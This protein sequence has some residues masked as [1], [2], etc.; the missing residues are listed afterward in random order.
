MITTLG[1]TTTLAAVNARK[2]EQFCFFF[3]RFVFQ[4][5]QETAPHSLDLLSCQAA[6]PSCM[7][8]ILDS[9]CQEGQLIGC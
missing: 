1:K 2:K 3:V 7:N 4:D 9:D 6:E 5:A 8:L